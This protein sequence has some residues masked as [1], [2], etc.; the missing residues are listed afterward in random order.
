MKVIFLL[1]TLLSSN[2]LLQAQ[3]NNCIV[4][5]IKLQIVIERNLLPRQDIECDYTG[6]SIIQ[7]Y[8]LNDSLAIKSL[9]AS[10]KGYNFDND[11]LLSKQLNKYYVD[12]FTKTCK[13]VIPML[14]YY[15][16]KKTSFEPS[17]KIKTTINEMREKMRTKNLQLL[18][19]LIL[20]DTKPTIDYE[21]E[22]TIAPIH[23]KTNHCC[24][25]SSL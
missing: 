22:P 4:D 25:K 3:K 12:S 11:A 23:Q 14:F 2:I 13:V 5:P 16:D 19:T 17:D 6:G 7:I 1:I 10:R 15:S 20:T 9:Y 24:S 21:P 18:E 8:K